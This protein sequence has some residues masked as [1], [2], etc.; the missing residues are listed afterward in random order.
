[1]SVEDEYKYLAINV[2]DGSIVEGYEPEFEEPNTVAKSFDDFLKKVIS[3]K[4]LL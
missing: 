3:G 4:L 1:M 2:N